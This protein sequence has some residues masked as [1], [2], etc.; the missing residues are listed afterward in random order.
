V[1][2]AAAPIA[3]AV[4]A[5]VLLSPAHAREGAS[6]VVDR[7][8]VCEVGYLGGVYQAT[9]ESYWFLPPQSER[10]IP[11]ATVATNLQNG[12]LARST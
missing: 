8:F 7:T 6:R 4:G 9:V 3:L 12:F 10:R 11:S 2:L 1:R 5:V